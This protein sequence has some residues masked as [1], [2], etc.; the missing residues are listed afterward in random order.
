MHRL[1]TANFTN[2]LFRSI[3]DED[4]DNPQCFCEQFVILKQAENTCGQF[5]IQITPRRGPY[6]NYS[7]VTDTLKKHIHEGESDISQLSA[8]RYMFNDT[9]SLFYSTVSLFVSTLVAY[10]RGYEKEIDDCRIVSIRWRIGQW[11]VPSFMA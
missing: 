9:E 10:L 6:L 11:T 3:S 7:L 4:N 8:P 1:S 5:D 2:L